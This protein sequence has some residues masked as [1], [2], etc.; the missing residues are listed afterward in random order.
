MVTM[1][2]KSKHRT[3]IQIY[4]SQNRVTNNQYPASLKIISSERLKKSI[5]NIRSCDRS[6]DRSGSSTT[7]E[8]RSVSTKK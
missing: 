5:E 8:L 7:G 2:P 1:F 3:T 6:T 4:I